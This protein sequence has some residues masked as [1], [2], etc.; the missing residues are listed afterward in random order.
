MRWKKKIFYILIALTS[1]SIILLLLLKIDNEKSQLDKIREG[2]VVERK[3]ELDSDLGEKKISDKSAG[4][5]TE[6]DDS[7]VR[8][9][10]SVFEKEISYISAI[11]FY[12]KIIDQNNDPVVGAKVLAV[13]N[14]YDRNLDEHIKHRGLR[15]RY[16]KI[17]KCSDDNGFFTI[18]KVK[19]LNLVIKGIEKEGYFASIDGKDT[20][21]F[22]KYHSSDVRHVAQKNNPVVFYL[23]K[24][25]RKTKLIH[26]KLK[27]KIRDNAKY[28]SIIFLEGKI[29]NE[30][31]NRGDLFA[32]LIIGDQNG[33]NR[34]DWKLVLKT[35]DGGIVETKDKY[36]FLAPKTGYNE[37]YTLQVNKSDEDWSIRASRKFY[38]RSINGKFFAAIN[39]KVWAY[40]DGRGM[41]ILE[42]YLN[43][44]GGRNLEPS[45]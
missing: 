6:N 26:K 35:I 39:A 28:Y 31:D 45:F 10:V 42:Y 41:L 43:D 12:G 11:E 8:G 4:F 37:N 32:K 24:E 33:S 44:K 25:G 13:I 27:I 2:V 9:L 18:D 15:Y 36:I 29:Y 17:Q 16:D 22:N 34:Y 23:W 19:G 7:M 1:I 3:K 21:V 38:F 14:T 5:P 40:H 30:Y 20:F